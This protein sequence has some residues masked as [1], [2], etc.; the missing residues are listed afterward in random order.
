MS[1]TILGIIAS[2]GSAAPSSYESIATVTVGSGGSSSI[3]FTS[4]PQTY[5]HLQL[6][7]FGQSSIPNTSD[8][9]ISLFF[10]GDALSISDSNYRQHRLFGNGSTA[11]AD[12]YSGYIISVRVP[13]SSNTS[14]FGGGIVDI[15]DYTNTNKYKTVRT[16]TGN[17]RNGAGSMYFNSG[18][19][20]KNLNAITSIKIGLS[21]SNLNQYS[22]FAL[23]GIKGS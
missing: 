6:R 1:S 10:N 18:L 21:G 11:S 8:T 12:T 17:D 22:S 2:S 9:D 20:I 15:L 7:C 14:M 13:N 3:D 4:I 5:A 16:L 19:Y 23:Y